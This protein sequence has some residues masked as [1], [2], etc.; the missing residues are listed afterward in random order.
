MEN[1]HDQYYILNKSSGS[2]YVF[3]C[4][5]WRRYNRE[6]EEQEK[7]LFLPM[8]FMYVSIGSCLFMFSL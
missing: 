1:L 5:I 7:V 6:E 3:C 2:I 8:S 4:C